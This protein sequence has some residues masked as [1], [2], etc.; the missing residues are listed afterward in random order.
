M[1]KRKPAPDATRDHKRTQDA[2]RE[3]LRR[4]RER[5]AKYQHKSCK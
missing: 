3:T 2:K 1:P 5:Q 4:K